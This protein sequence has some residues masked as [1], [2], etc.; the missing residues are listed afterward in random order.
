MDLVEIKGTGEEENGRKLSFSAQ[1]RWINDSTDERRFH[2]EMQ[3][4]SG[5]VNYRIPILEA[6]LVI[7]LG[8]IGLLL[9][10]VD[11][12]SIITEHFEIQGKAIKMNKRDQILGIKIHGY[13]RNSDMKTSGSDIVLKMSIL[14]AIGQIISIKTKS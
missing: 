10:N 1:G 3:K 9:E 4:N 11:E 8:A 2:F 13:K 14:E 7:T 6:K 5:S 12:L